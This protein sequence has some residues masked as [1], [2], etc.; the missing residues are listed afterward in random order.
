MPTTCKKPHQYSSRKAIVSKKARNPLWE[1]T[2]PDGTKR[3][4]K[5]VPKQSKR[6]RTTTPKGKKR[7][8]RRTKEWINR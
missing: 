5:R 3:Y 2:M 4:A 1:Y 7:V 8:D 6:C